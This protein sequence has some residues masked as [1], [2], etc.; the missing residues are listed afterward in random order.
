VIILSFVRS[1]VK[2]RVGRLLEDFRRLNVALTRAKYKLIMVGSF[3]TLYRGS[4]VLK[5]VLD[6]VRKESRVVD[7]LQGVN[8]V[9]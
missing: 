8:L 2:G 6:R 7:P 5:P 1:N 4:D 3:S 9:N